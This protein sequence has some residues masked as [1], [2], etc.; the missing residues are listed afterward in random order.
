MNDDV[1]PEEF[2]DLLNKIYQFGYAAGSDQQVSGDFDAIR[3]RML[4]HDATQRANAG[5]DPLATA[6]LRQVVRAHGPRLNFPSECDLWDATNAFIK[7]GAP[8]VGNDNGN[9]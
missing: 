3:A 9:I 6:V 4:A 8:G 1:S 2:D 7:A 5:N